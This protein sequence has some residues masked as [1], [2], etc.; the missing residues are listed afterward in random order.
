MAVEAYK[1]QDSSGPVAL[2]DNIMN[3]LKME[4]QEDDME[5]KQAQKDYQE[6]MKISAEKRSTDGKTIVEK[7]GQK[8]GAE[9]K[10]AK[11]K[12]EHKG[13]TTELAAIVEYISNLHKE[14]DFL[15]QNFDAR[16]TARTNEIEAIGKARSVLNG[17]DVFFMQMGEKKFMSARKQM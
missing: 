4:M 6:M 2:L 11:A 3:D 9:E 10:L 1:K 15:V 17:A 12:H 5:E 7:E 14:C 16:K 13:S 8:A